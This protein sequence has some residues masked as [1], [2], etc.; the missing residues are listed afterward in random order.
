MGRKMFKA[1]GFYLGK[2][3]LGGCGGAIGGSI[4]NTLF[5]VVIATIR[6][7]F[8][9]K[10]L[11][12]DPALIATAISGLISGALIGVIVGPLFVLNLKKQESNLWEKLLP[13]FV[14]VGLSAFLVGY[15]ISTQNISSPSKIL[16]LIISGGSSGWLSAIMTSLIYQIVNYS[17]SGGNYL[18]KFFLAAIIF[19]AFLGSY[20]FYPTLTG[21]DFPVPPDIYSTTYHKMDVLVNGDVNILDQSGEIL[22]T[23]ENELSKYNS[24]ESLNSN[25]IVISELL[26]TAFKQFGARP[27]GRPDNN[28]KIILARTGI[29]TDILIKVPC[30]E[31]NSF[32]YHYRYYEW[33]YLSGTSTYSLGDSYCCSFYNISLVS[34]FDEMKQAVI[35]IASEHGALSLRSYQLFL[36]RLPSGEWIVVGVKPGLMS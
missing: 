10:W 18:L 9:T 22:S 34:V 11:L 14:G 19:C 2:I 21:N 12:Q 13:L 4:A 20:L 28:S 15:S 1:L 6:A 30:P 33:P 8:S 27:L 16:E 36:E 32:C 5:A 17:D 26:R 7:D 23:F 24:E 35:V 29:H 31:Q 3:I 25:G